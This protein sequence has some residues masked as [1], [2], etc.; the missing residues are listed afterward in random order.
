M[1]AW[2]RLSLRT[3]HHL[4]SDAVIV[5]SPSPDG[6]AGELLCRNVGTFALELDPCPSADDELELLVVASAVP[7][8]RCGSP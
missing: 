1:Q 8:R 2:D 3:A 4:A 7:D 5:L 6:A